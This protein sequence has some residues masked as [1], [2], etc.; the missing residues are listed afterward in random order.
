MR[1]RLAKAAFE[2]IRDKGHSAFRTA[3]V[4][5]YA[6]VSE[7]AQQ[8]HFA[9]KEDLVLAALEY[10][11]SQAQL[12]SERIAAGVAS[13]DD[14]VNGMIEDFKVFFLGDEFWAGLD[15]TIAASKS[16][17]F[18]RDVKTAVSRYRGPVYALWIDTL[19]EAGWARKDAEEI[20]TMTAA[21]IAGLSMRGLWT[22]IVPQLKPILARWFKVA[23][24]EWPRK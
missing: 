23:K 2:V 4:A 24:R 6:G 13:A 16:D 14:A 10:G 19:H 11:F 12:R 22:D 1:A 18:A 9:T 7:G 17:G 5:T 21:L 8:H 15:I 3:M 20:V